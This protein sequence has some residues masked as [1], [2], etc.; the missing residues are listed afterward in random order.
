MG[1]RLFLF[2]IVFLFGV[3]SYTGASVKPSFLY[4]LSNFDGVISSNWAVVEVDKNRDEVYMLD[5]RKQVIRIFNE[6]GMEIYRF[7]DDGSLGT[8]QD[9]AVEA[10]GNILVL[11]RNV[12]QTSIIRCNFRGERISDVSLQNLPEEYLP[13]SPN[14]MGYRKGMVYLLDSLTMRLA[15][16]DAKGNFQNGYDLA[17]IIDVEDQKRAETDV[18]G[19]SVD[20][21]GNILFTVPVFFSAYRLSPDGKIRG[22]G[23]PGS[24]P[25][26]FGVVGDIDSDDRGNLYVADRLKCVVLIFDKDFK[27]QAEFGY[28]GP[29]ADNLIG[30]KNLALDSHNRLYISQLAGRGISVFQLNYQFSI[31]NDN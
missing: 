13:F 9:V 29:R 6:K 22:F 7:G 17:R 30:P 26:R 21:D 15:V 14:H 4:Y 27:F 2:I 5:P 12:S 20:R 23:R 1:A 31:T 8:M 25:G 28:R 3:P 19:F 16:V 24:A 10:D 11:S 18:G